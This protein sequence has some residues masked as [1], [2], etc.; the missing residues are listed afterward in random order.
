MPITAAAPGASGSTAATS[1]ALLLEVERA[2]AAAVGV[3]VAGEVDGD[4]R[5]I[6]RQGDRVPGVRVLGAAVEEDELGIGS[7]PTREALSW[8]PSSRSAPSRRT[9][10][11]PS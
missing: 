8:R 11:G 6:E 7:H 1:A 4:E 10:G 5:T 3:T 2:V 9:T